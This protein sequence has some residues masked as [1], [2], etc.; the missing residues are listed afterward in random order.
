[1]FQ[2]KCT[3][4]FYFPLPVHNFKPLLTYPLSPKCV[5]HCNWYTLC[6]TPAIVILDEGYRKSTALTSKNTEPIFFYFFFL[7]PPRFVLPSHESLN[8]RIKVMEATSWND[9]CHLTSNETDR[10]NYRAENC[11]STLILPSRHT[12][13]L[14]RRHLINTREHLKSVHKIFVE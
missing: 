12:L 11:S 7:Y 8:S 5:L 14:T 1:M 10:I 3:I 2:N 4:S 13:I 9:K 6:H